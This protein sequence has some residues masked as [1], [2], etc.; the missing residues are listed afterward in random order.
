MKINLISVF[1]IITSLTYGYLCGSG[2]YGFNVDYY[3]E[4][5]KEN[6]VYDLIFDTAGSL[7]S[8]LTINNFHVG[9]YLTSFVLSFS[10]GYFINKC[11]IINL[12]INNLKNDIYHKLFFLIIYLIT[13]HIHP[14]IMSTSGAMRQGWAMSIIFFILTLILSK[15]FFL[16]F[17][18]CFILISLHKSGIIYISYFIYTFLIFNILKRFNYNKLIFLFF[19]GIFFFVVIL[20]I[21]IEVKIFKF[22]NQDT[23]IVFGDFRFFWLSLNLIYVF[24]YLKFYEYNLISLFRYPALFLY[25]ASFGNIVFL[26]LGFNDQ[27]E[28][29]NMMIGVPYIYIT[30]LMYKINFY[31]LILIATSFYLF[32]TIYQGMYDIGL[33]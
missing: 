32:L 12:E 23:R 7:L 1:L 28:R 27:Y 22:N 29:L 17:F 3:A 24:I 21:M 16:S 13:L 19:S 25:F 2:F 8:T 18:F 5:Y 11:L 10:V 14:L 30:S 31:Y 20:L 15:K 26:F 9:V 6:L 4:Y 33:F